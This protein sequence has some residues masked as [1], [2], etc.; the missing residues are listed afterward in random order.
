MIEPLARR[1]TLEELFVQLMERQPPEYQLSPAVLGKGSYCD[2][3]YLLAWA[4]SSDRAK[5]PSQVSLREATEALLLLGFR[6]EL[7]PR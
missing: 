3:R 5:P 7:S 4:R 6:P 2:V 1:Y